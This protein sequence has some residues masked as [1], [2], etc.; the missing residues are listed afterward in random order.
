[1]ISKVPAGKKALLINMNE[2][3]VCLYPGTGKG[4]VIIREV[5]VVLFFAVAAPTTNQKTTEGAGHF[6]RGS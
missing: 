6:Q 2:T 5:H 1:M 4:T 3:A